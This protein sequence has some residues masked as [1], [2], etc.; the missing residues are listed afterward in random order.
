MTS[1][2]SVLSAVG[3]LCHLVEYPR[4]SALDPGGAVVQSHALQNFV[5]LDQPAETVDTGVYI[6]LKSAEIPTLC[7]GNFGRHFAFADALDKRRR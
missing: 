1:I 6:V 2:E 3:R 4:I 5:C 7:V